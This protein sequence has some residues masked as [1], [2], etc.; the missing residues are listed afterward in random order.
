VPF[1]NKP[2]A[3]FTS[4]MHLI[5]WICPRGSETKAIIRKLTFLHATDYNQKTVR[6]ATFGHKPTAYCNS[7]N[8]NDFT[9]LDVH[10]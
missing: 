1:K 10:M 2:C 4:G 9:I 8:S 3:N 7:R 6:L 5:S